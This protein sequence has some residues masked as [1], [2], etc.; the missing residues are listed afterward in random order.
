MESITVTQYLI[1]KPF[2]SVSL[3]L[4]LTRR[5]ATAN[6]SRVSIRGRVHR[7]KKTLPHICLCAHVG[8]QK[9]LGDA[10]APF[11]GRKV[12]LTPWKHATAY[13]C[14]CTKFRRCGSNRLGVG[15]IRKI[16]GRWKLILRAKLNCE[17]RSIFGKV[18]GKSTVSCF[19]D[20]RGIKQLHYVHIYHCGGMTRPL[21]SRNQ[22]PTR[23]LTLR[24]P[25][26]HQSQADSSVAQPLAFF[27]PNFVKIDWTICAF[28]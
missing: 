6:R 14:Y 11:L 15:R 1:R 8:G 9:I 2:F 17:N 20:S 24:D 16:W 5:L 3:T 27:P 12:W 25:D 22:N 13:V 7:V 21:L 10:G 23:I 26:Y 18:L 19:F 28:C 4:L